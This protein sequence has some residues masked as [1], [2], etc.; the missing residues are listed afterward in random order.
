M[1]V[2]L[3]FGIVQLYY[4]SRDGQSLG[5]KI[6]GIRVLKS[7]GS[8]PGFE[9][10]VLIREVVWALAVG[11][12]VT[13]VSLAISDTGGNLISLLIAFINFIM[14]FSVKRDRRTLYDM[15]ADTV[16]VKLPPRR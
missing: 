13:I 7:D 2:Y 11:V 1:A 9:G 10:T 16:V 3:V 6:M 8:N 5:K 15:L 12:V 14:L 4:M